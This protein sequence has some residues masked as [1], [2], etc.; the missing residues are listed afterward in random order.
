MSF[1]EMQEDVL[2][3]LYENTIELLKDAT[4][5]EKQEILHQM[6]SAFFASLG[7]IGQHED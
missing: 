1:R 4:P 6:N 2:K 7:R 3:R 5:K